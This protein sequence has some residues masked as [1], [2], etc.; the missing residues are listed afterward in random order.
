MTLLSAPAPPRQGGHVLPS[1]ALKLCVA[2]YRVSTQKQGRSGLG[3]E[4]QQ[5]AVRDH[6]SATGRKLIYEFTEIESGK[7]P[8]RPKLAEALKICRLTVAKLV[9]ARLDRLAR[10][11]SF[12]S[13]VMESGVE[14]E[15]VDFP[16]ANRLTVHIIAAVAEYEGRLISTRTKVALAA[17]KARGVKLGGN[18][19][20]PGNPAGLAK[21]RAV[22]TTRSAARAADLAPL[23]AELTAGGYVSRTAIAREFNARGIRAP[24]GGAWSGGMVQG[25]LKRLSIRIGAAEYHG[26]RRAARSTWL[27]GIAPV[28]AKIVASGITIPEHI[29]RVLDRRRIPTQ[30]GGRWAGVQVRNAL[31]QLMKTADDV[32]ACDAPLEGGMTV[33]VI[34]P[35]Y[36]LRR[37]H[38]RTTFFKRGTI[39]PAALDVLRR[40]RRPL[41]V[42][43]IALAIF[44]AKQIKQPS[45]QQV[46]GLYNAVEANLRNADGK[47]VRR[48]RIKGA[49]A[50][51]IDE[52]HGAATSSA[53]AY[54]TIMVR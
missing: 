8:D 15:A 17:A 14:F 22:Q 6:V 30:R 51:E 38:R 32:N 9:V 49:D 41:A 11:V 23:I 5:R 25:A 19:G 12:V 47:M 18:R 29:A 20:S 13:G 36:V 42:R 31:K 24:R 45:A 7:N 2:Y 54:R 4:A 35:P 39:F 52:A 26:A 10:S 50:V 43:N 37:H 33:Q 28:I 46:R 44:K 3:L 34:V 21:A 1:P 16:Q 53:S 48:I 27:A 40:A